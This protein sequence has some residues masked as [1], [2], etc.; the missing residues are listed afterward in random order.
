[1]R[2]L[3]THLI[4]KSLDRETVTREVAFVKELDLSGAQIR[5]IRQR[6][7]LTQ[8]QLADLMQTGISTISAIENDAGQR[9]PPV[10][11]CQLLLAYDAGFRPSQWPVQKDL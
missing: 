10:R 7:G 6:L 11:F 5:G 1:M 3:P 9:K 4:A 8:R 2:D